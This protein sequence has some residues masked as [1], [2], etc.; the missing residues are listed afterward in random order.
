MGLGSLGSQAATARA[1]AMQAQAEL[2]SRQGS[3]QAGAVSLIP[4][5]ELAVGTPFPHLFR[6]WE[7]FSA[8]A[9]TRQSSLCA[10]CKISAQSFLQGM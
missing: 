4:H 8:A 7:L 10:L 9:Y 1:A 2:V 6:A 5:V 3:F